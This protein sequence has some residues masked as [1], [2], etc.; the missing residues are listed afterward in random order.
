MFYK[1][2]VKKENPQTKNDLLDSFVM[3]E[4]NCK[5]ARGGCQQVSIHSKYDMKE[6]KD[7]TVFYNEDVDFYFISVENELCKNFIDE[8]DFEKI[9]DFPKDLKLMAGNYGSIAAGLDWY[10][11]K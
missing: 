9:D 4:Y 2:S 3:L 11:N 7:K 1:K 8:W 5:N 6:G 10:K